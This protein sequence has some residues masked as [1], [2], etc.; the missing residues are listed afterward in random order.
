MK[1]LVYSL[2]ILEVTKALI[3]SIDD[4]EDGHWELAMQTETLTA[5]LPSISPNQQQATLPGAVIRVLGFRIIKRDAPNLAT[6][7]VMDGK[8][9]NDTFGVD[10]RLEG[11][12][13][14]VEADSGCPGEG[15]TAS[16]E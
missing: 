1:E 9:L 5:T 11:S 4:I 15:V 7:T 14:T 12:G 3:N 6:V 10:S 16:F 8:V 2:N 13:G